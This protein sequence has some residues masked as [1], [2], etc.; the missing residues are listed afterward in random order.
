MVKVVSN[1]NFVMKTLIIV[2]PPSGKIWGT[3][4]HIFF[5][6]IHSLTAKRVAAQI[7]LLP[8]RYMGGADHIQK[9][10]INVS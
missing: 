8:I 4:I 7:K 6:I 10:D 5:Q 1:A 3:E 2:V 9:V